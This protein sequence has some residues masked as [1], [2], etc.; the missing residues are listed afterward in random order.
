MVTNHAPTVISLFT[1]I[2]CLDYAFVKAGF[3][4]VA[5]VEIDPFCRAVLAKHAPT[6]WPNA[7]VFEDVL[8]ITQA[9]LG[10]TDVLIGGF[11]CQDVSYAGKRQGITSDTRS[12]LWSHYA[13]LIGDLRPRIAL[14]ENVPGILS[15][16]GIRVI[17]DLARMGYDA[18][19]CVVPAALVG[20]PHERKRW[21]CVAYPNNGRC[22]VAWHG[23]QDDHDA[24][25]FHSE[26]RS[27][28]DAIQF[29]LGANSQSLGDATRERIE[30]AQ[31]S[32]QPPSPFSASEIVGDADGQRQSQSKWS[33]REFGRWAEYDGKTLDDA[34]S[35]GRARQER[36]KTAFRAVARSSDGTTQSIVGR[37]VDGFARGMDG[38]RWP[39]PPGEAQHEWEASRTTQAKVANRVNRLKA[40]GNGVVWQMIYP[41]AVA[42]KAALEEGDSEVLA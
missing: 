24:F 1:G 31:F 14:L 27:E 23:Q 40:L 6:Y 10:T 18:E 3:E 21:V 39:A 12:G 42:I 37:A 17:A 2:G 9:E 8:T 4:I 26:D 28:R 15:K 19:W 34:S 16:D 20:A 33:K 25:G 22:R 13:R 29:R 11:P 36:S 5:Q 35:A 41:F 38:H 30:P 7:K 32:G